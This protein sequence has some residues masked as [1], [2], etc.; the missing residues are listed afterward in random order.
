ME[1]YSLLM[2]PDAGGVGSI[3]V[4][5]GAHPPLSLLP[6]FPSPFPFFFPSHPSLSLLFTPLYS[7]PLKSSPLNSS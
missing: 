7:P 2:Q 5:G 6:S 3:F 4:W 1:F